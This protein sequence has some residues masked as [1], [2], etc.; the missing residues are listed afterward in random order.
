M[1]LAA[2]AGGGRFP[3]FGVSVLLPVLLM[4]LLRRRQRLVLLRRL[5][6]WTMTETMMVLPRCQ[7]EVEVE[8]GDNDGLESSPWT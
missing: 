7:L 8:E 1:L 6:P 2:G 5:D 3:L 4:L